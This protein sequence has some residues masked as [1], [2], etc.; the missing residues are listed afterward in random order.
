METTTAAQ[1]EESQTE[2]IMPENLTLKQMQEI[3]I[4]KYKLDQND[5]TGRKVPHGSEAQDLPESIIKLLNGTVNLKR[6]N[7]T[8][9]IENITKGSLN[10]DESYVTGYSQAQIPTAENKDRFNQEEISVTKDTPD[11]DTSTTITNESGENVE[12]RTNE[13]D[14]DTE[15][16]NTS[17][18]STEEQTDNY[19]QRTT[20]S[21]GENDSE[22]DVMPIKIIMH[23][24]HV[25]LDEK[26]CQRHEY[27]VLKFGQPEYHGH[28]EYNDDSAS[29]ETY[30][31]ESGSGESVS[32]EDDKRRRNRGE[33]E[34]KESI[35]GEAHM[36]VV[37]DK[38]ES[39]GFYG[40]DS[41]YWR[42][43]GNTAYQ[44]EPLIEDQRGEVDL[45]P[46]IHCLFDAD[47]S[48][49]KSF[50]FR[51][52]KGQ[53]QMSQRDSKTGLKLSR[54]LRILNQL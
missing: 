10:L 35:E 53:V 52:P 40:E 5:Y 15:L 30:E 2:D 42:N 47:C 25:H 6:E 21:S 38:D 27:L 4:E 17:T 48:K 22:N 46:V 31:A 26:P 18:S 3:V 37:Y 54:K 19:I 44:E 16:W 43:F 49:L 9:G 24:P 32:D 12:G 33:N 50:R 41:E 1:V 39:P 7:S 45:E 51:I 14:S 8:A 23:A 20:E 28:L 29:N 11:G 34:C 13:T 36:G